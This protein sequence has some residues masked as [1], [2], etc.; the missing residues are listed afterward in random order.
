VDEING[1]LGRMQLFKGGIMRLQWEPRPRESADA[2]DPRRLDELLA[3]RGIALDETRRGE[4][5]DIFRNMVGDIRRKNRDQEL[6]VDYPTALRRVVDYTQW[7]TLTVQR[8]DD[9]GRWMPLTKR[10]YGQ[11]SGGRRTLDLLLPLI[12]A[13]SARQKVSTA[14]VALPRMTTAP[15]SA[16]RC[17]ATAR[18]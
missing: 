15:S 16:A 11:G 3:Q 10:L 13:V 4:L 8:R 9:S 5:L 17:S 2:F 6:L 14:G 12:A 18:A 1:T 7:Y